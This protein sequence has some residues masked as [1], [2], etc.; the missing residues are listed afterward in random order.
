[1]KAQVVP[2]RCQFPI[3]L[4]HGLFGF[5]ERRLGAV[6]FTYFRGVAPYLESVG[7]RVVAIP[8]P[9]CGRI[10]DRARKIAHALDT[11][12]DLKD[13]P[14]NVIAHSM[15]GLDGR[16]L[17]SRLGYGD[18]VRSLTT[19]VTPHRGSYLANGLIIPGL[20]RAFKWLIPALQDLN[21]KALVRF[22]EETPDRPGTRY[23]SIPAKTGFIP[24]TPF[25]WPTYLFLLA[26]RGAND[27]QV[28]LDSAKWGEVLEEARADHIQ[29]IGLRLGLNA[30]TCENHLDLYGRITMRLFG[31]GF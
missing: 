14:V 11:H 28:P 10:E 4:L 25:L 27:G 17:I 2:A 6:R 23:F 16:Y 3:V 26:V 9:S 5:V 19:I 22:N 18:R 12:P 24:C 13:L 1:V 20:G 30:W 21:E 7:N 29:L 15:G 8:V 31:S